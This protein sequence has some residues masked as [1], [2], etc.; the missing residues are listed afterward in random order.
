M[1]FL[2]AGIL[3][4]ALLSSGI[5][6]SQTTQPEKTFTHAD[7]LR[8]AWTALRWCYDVTFYHLDVRI[9]P[10]SQTVEGSNDIRFTV[11]QD[12][13][14]LQIDLFKNM[15]LRSVSLDGRQPCTFVRDGNAVF[16]S[17]PVRLRKGENHSLLLAYGGKP[18]VARRPPWDGGFIWTKDSTGG[19]WVAVTCEGT[20]ASL[21]WPNKD[22]PADEPD[23]MLISITVPS[24]LE[25]ISNGRLRAKTAVGRGWTRY[26]WFVSYP[27]NNYCV[28]VNIGKFAHFADTFT[29]IDTVSLDYYVLPQNLERAKRQF[30]QVKTMLAAFE[31]SFGPYPFARDGYKL[32]DAPHNGMEHQSCV[33]YGNGYTNGYRGISSSAEGQTFDFI[34]IHESAHEWWGNSVTASDNADMW[35]HESFA[36]YAEALYVEKELGR[37]ASLRYIN[38]KKQ[39]VRN[40]APMQGMYGLNDEGSGDMYDKGQLVLNTLRSSLDND[41][42]WFA[43]LRG[44]QSR[45]RY[46]TVSYDTLVNY[47]S[48]ATGR[49]LHPFFDQYYRHAALPRLDLF[50]TKHGD[51]VSVRYR[52]AGTTEGFEMPVKVTSA[53]GVWSTIYPKSAWQSLT[54]DPHLDPWAFKVAENLFYCDIHI[55]H[56]YINPQVPL[57]GR[58]IF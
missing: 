10:D 42:L 16:V 9:D 31:S 38:A 18:I 43:V 26:D 28:T 29:G 7:S 13:T 52:W 49:D 3:A 53:E 39:N 25:D 58:R 12:C 22:H 11:L 57:P 32:V 21:W 45:Y 15:D 17:M 27:I 5:T 48:E 55:V 54:V 8:G 51:S 36:A 50:V 47:L 24:G 4:A 40:A 23:S 33:A 44:I 1:R 2:M 19:P 37:E 41:S 6:R 30:A 35:I 20:G 56:T 14:E 46:K 34:I